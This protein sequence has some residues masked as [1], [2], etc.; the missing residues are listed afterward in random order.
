MTTPLN[1]P[2][3][4][5]VH[6]CS[7]LFL[8]SVGVC[9]TL[10]FY[11]LCGSLVL[12]GLEGVSPGDPQLEGMI[13]MEVQTQLKSDLI[14]NQRNLTVDKLW[15]ITERLNI[16]YKD[17]WTV[18]ASQEIIKFQIEL[19]KELKQEVAKTNGICKDPGG[20][21]GQ[22]QE[23]YWTFSSAFLYSLTLVTTIGWCG[24]Y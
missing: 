22:G 9:L 3:S 19:V 5:C 11:I 18:M 6:L 2:C 21:P 15:N 13:P 4:R 7:S 17:N 16:L 8:N 10:V 20:G 23:Q 12:L 1:N 24:E 14:E